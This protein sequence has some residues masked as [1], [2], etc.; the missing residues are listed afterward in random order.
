MSKKIA[1]VRL[2]AVF[3]LRFAMVNRNYEKVFAFLEKNYK[4]IP[5][6]VYGGNPFKTLVSTLLSARTRDETTLTICERLFKKAPDF[7][8][9]AQM[10]TNQIAK[11]IYP[12]GFYREKAKNLRKTAEILTTKYKGRVPDN[13]D[14]LT[15]LPGVG[16]KTANLILARAYNQD[17]ISVDTHVHKIT[18]LLGWVKTKTPE[19]TEKELIKIIPKKYWRE[20]NR[21]FVSLGRQFRS[22]RKLVEFLEEHKPILA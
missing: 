5:L 16:R 8:Q 4:E 22:R 9:I 7:N 2:E 17:A 10:P 21:L 19:Q 3:L 20:I 12:A 18:N 6:E 11:L 13:I 1:Q 15:K 14:K